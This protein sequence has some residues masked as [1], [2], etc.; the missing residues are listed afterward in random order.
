M[1]RSRAAARERH[2]LVPWARRVTEG[3]VVS[4][5]AFTGE[6][7]EY[8]KGFMAGVEARRA[9][10]GLPLAPPGEGGGG[11]DPSDL[12]RA[13][14]DRVIAEG[15]KLVA[16]EEAKRKKHPLDRWDEINALAGEGKFPKGTDVFLTKYFGM[17]YVA[18]AQN[19]F[20]CRLR[21][22]G[23]IM[24]AHQFRGVAWIADDL[25]G[26]YADVTT[27][28]NLQLREITAAGA[29]EVVVRLSEIGLTSRG[30]GADNIRN[31][32]G[33][34]TAGIDPQELLDTRPHAR[35]LHHHILN[36][37]ELYGLPRKFNIAFD[38]GGRVPVLED[39][40]DIAFSAVAVA[41]GFGVA[42]GV[43]YRLALGGITGH[44]DLAKE[45]GVIVP[46]LDATRVAD[47]IVRVFIRSGDRTDRTK[48]R[49]KYVLDAW[50]VPKFLDAVEQEL[51]GPLLRVD[52]A[53]VLA[54]P[55]QEKHGHLGVHGQKQPGLSYVGVLTPVGRLSSERMRGLADIAERCGS[56]TLRLT[57]W[58]NLLISDI[59]DDRLQH[60]LDGIAA[61]GLAWEASAV[62]GGLVA[63]T[64]NAGCKF[65]AS[66][67]KLH[68]AGLAD[69]LDARIAVDQPINIHL[70]GCHHSCAQ[71]YIAD[72]G[73][74][75]AKVERGE[76]M[77]EGYDLHVGGGA[78]SEARIGRLIR[79]AIPYDDLPPMVLSLLRAWLDGREPG[80]NF[81]AWCARHS[82]AQL[83]G[84]AEAPLEAMAA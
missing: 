40:N 2:R 47:A 27:R 16:E 62:R 51:G 49:L 9:A 44:K 72:I 21:I 83:R 24:S 58:Q 77:I 20:M 23:G 12:Q 48:A 39:T 18:P 25:A 14:Q 42:A 59:P 78:G 60:A 32:T 35:T 5:D 36:H 8:L 28:A 30:A 29:P 84:I 64:G 52:A 1:R 50:G 55:A 82:D 71:H 4:D 15:G 63:C 37:R 45:T 17:F 11:G 57:V 34:P 31:V 79:P 75:A 41:D 3:A 61:L 26:G 66:D 76:D 81:W 67:T 19:A 53:A 56:G 65:S 22:P 80:E 7:Q 69:W 74:L 54:R 33:S 43:Y 68:G 38:G 70:T 13:A 10:L 73:L 6:Q 46:P